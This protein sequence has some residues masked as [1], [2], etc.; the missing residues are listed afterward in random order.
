MIAEDKI[1][2]FEKTV[3]DISLIQQNQDTDIFRDIIIQYP[4][5]QTAQLLYLLS[6]NQVESIFSDEELVQAAIYSG[7]RT[8][9]YFYLSGERNI[10]VNQPEITKSDES[11][12]EYET[13]LPAT[14]AAKTKV[15]KEQANLLIDK[16][17]Q[18]NPSIQKTVSEF[19]SPSGMAA[20]SLEEDVDLA[21]ETLAKIYIKK[22]NYAKAIRIYQKLMLYYPEKS[23]YFATL[24]ESLKDKTNE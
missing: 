14:E 4:F 15:P 6:K 23:N 13:Y 7:S 24:I 11:T 21:T 18:E 1:S 16:F 12:L 20:K 22:G 10:S 5:F 19:F 17:I 3:N 8:K 9:L 2:F